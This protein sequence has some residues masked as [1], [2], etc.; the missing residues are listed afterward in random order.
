MLVNTKTNAPPPTTNRTYY[1]QMA[2][3]PLTVLSTSPLSSPATSPSRSP[4]RTGA[5]GRKRRSPPATA[6]SSTHST[7]PSQSSSSSSSSTQSSSTSSSTRGT[8]RRRRISEFEKLVYILQQLKDLRWTIKDLLSAICTN[9]S[10]HRIR[11]AQGQFLDFAYTDLIKDDDFLRLLGQ[12]R[13]AAFT[14]GRPWGWAMETLRQEIR[15]IASKPSLCKFQQP[16]VT[17]DLGSVD[18]VRKIA[19]TIK[20]VA[21]RWLELIEVAS[22]DSFVAKDVDVQSVSPAGCH[23]VILALLCHKLRPNRANNL[24]TV[25]GLYLFQGGARRRVIDT[26]CQFGL[27][28]SYT[29]LQRRMASLTGEAARKA[30]VVGQSY[31]GIVTYDNFDFTEGKRGERTGDSRTMRSITTSLIF[32]GRGFDHGPLT[33]G[34]WRPALH[35]LSAIEVAKKL[36]PGDIDDEVRFDLHPAVGLTYSMLLKCINL[37]LDPPLPS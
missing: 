23:A 19:A 16:S 2:T 12:Q 7:L 20:E 26:F 10:K 22:D 1:H 6:S 17:S 27:T 11:K 32:Q 34:M 33:Q 29:T 31:D 36:E 8:K 14:E 9:S 35:P 24:Q 28:M 15:A 37:S 30:Q 5:R 13:K 25:L 18:A 3:S 4:N 21:P